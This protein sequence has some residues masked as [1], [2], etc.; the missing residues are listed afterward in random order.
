MEP[1][2]VGIND[3]TIWFEANTGDEPKTAVDLRK[4][5]DKASVIAYTQPT[6]L[7]GEILLINESDSP[8]YIQLFDRIGI[9][10][11][12]PDVIFKEQLNSLF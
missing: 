3:R 12:M 7:G 6:I 10:I 4:K 1:I 11:I 2:E 8:K 5:K 9:A